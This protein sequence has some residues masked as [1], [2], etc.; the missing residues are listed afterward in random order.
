MREHVRHNIVLAQVVD[1]C[2]IVGSQVLSPADELA[3]LPLALGLRQTGQDLLQ[4]MLISVDSEGVAQEVLLELLD[5]PEA[6]LS[7]PYL[8]ALS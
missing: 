8:V 4:C 6:P 3:G 2:E 7:S 1:Q 5:S